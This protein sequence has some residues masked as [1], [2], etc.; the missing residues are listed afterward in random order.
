MVLHVERYDAR[1]RSEAFRRAIGEE[2]FPP[3]LIHG[4]PDS[5]VWWDR[6]RRW[7]PELHVVL[8]DDDGPVASAWGVP[9]AWS[10]AV[11]DLP[12][13]YTE[14]LRRAVE[15]HE[16]GARPT[17]LVVCAAV[18]LPERARS[19]L[20]G[21]LLEAMRDLPAAAHLAHVLVPVR[22][23]LKGRYPLADIDA[24]TRWARP[25]GLPLD[26]WLRTHVRIGGRIIATAPAS[27]TLRASVADWEA[28]SGLALPAS[29]PY[30]VPDAP[31][32]LVVDR[33]ADVGVLV[34]PNV[35]VQHR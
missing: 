6:V 11:D 16:Q 35:W 12:S 2:A 5:D 8:E 20:A 30:V 27:Q 26:P 4:D 3:W 7:F 25:D 32:P 13:G 24:F 31:A 18:V 21:R 17:A 9:L 29:G 1:E 10:G 33:D 15:G 23:T 22:P 19:G 28:W 14:S 34:E